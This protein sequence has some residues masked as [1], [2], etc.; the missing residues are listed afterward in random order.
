MRIA[1]SG[2]HGTGKST[3]ISWA[4]ADPIKRRAV[5]DCPIR[6]GTD[7]YFMKS[8]TRSGT[9]KHLYEASKSRCGVMRRWCRTDRMML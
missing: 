9:S 2:S 7:E 4:A 1:V 3:L 6:P 8:F 5:L